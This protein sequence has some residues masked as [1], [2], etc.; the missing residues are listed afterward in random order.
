MLPCSKI[1]TENI[2]KN[3]NE[4]IYVHCL[5]FFVS[6]REKRHVHEL[7]KTNP[8]QIVSKGILFIDVLF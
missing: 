2:K 8:V 6:K 1:S 4:I 7:Q 3:I 5:F